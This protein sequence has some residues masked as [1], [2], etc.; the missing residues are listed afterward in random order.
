MPDGLLEQR[1]FELRFE[2]CEAIRCQLEV[3][4][5]R[6]V[7]GVRPALCPEDFCGAFQWHEVSRVQVDR[8]SMHPGAVLHPPGDILWAAPDDCVV[9]G[10]QKVKRWPIMHLPRPLSPDRH[11]LPILPT[12]ATPMADE[13][14]DL[15]WMCRHLECGA[16]VTT[17]SAQ[18]LSLLGGRRA[19]ALSCAHRAL[20]ACSA[21][22]TAVRCTSGSLIRVP[23]RSQ[24]GHPQCSHAPERSAPLPSSYG[25]GFNSTPR[26]PA[27]RS[28][29]GCRRSEFASSVSPPQGESP[30]LGVL[31][32]SAAPS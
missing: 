6:A 32:S 1:S 2:T 28:S 25:S 15:I 27:P 3:Q 8:Q 18:N 7:A 29:A 10:D 30:P 11:G 12:G 9:P 23:R 19:V 24:L 16:D 13:R 14:H 20:T 5:N 17:V 21:A 31:H 22:H 26:E 4:R